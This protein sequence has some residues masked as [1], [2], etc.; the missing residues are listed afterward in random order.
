MTRTI[1]SIACVSSLLLF[2]S[3]FLFESGACAADWSQPAE[4]RYEDAL[5]ISYTARV[6]GPYLVVRANVGQGWHTFALDNVQRVEEKLAG[7]PSLSMDRSTEIAVAG[8]QVEG[9][10]HQSPPKDFSRPNL[11]MFSFGYDRDVIFAAKV[12]PAGAGSAKLRIRGQA[13]TETVCKNIDVPLTVAVPAKPG[14]SAEVKLQELVQ[15]R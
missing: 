15:A 14:T 6:D 12:R 2:A 13:C 9:P 3:L 5:V 10:W 11:R 1:A 4:V 7:K 8:V